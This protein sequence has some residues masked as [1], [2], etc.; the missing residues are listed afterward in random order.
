MQRALHT[1]NALLHCAC[2][3]HS[4]IAYM[5]CIY[6]LRNAC[7]HGQQC[8]QK[9]MGGVICC[10][11]AVARFDLCSAAARCESG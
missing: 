7:V 1:C 2:A 11:V 8:V 4:C 10:V 5:Q 9:P 3:M 6:A